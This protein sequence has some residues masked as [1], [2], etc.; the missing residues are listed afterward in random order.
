MRLNLISAPV[1]PV[2][3]VAPHLRKVPLTRARRESLRKQPQ[4]G[5]TGASHAEGDVR[6][7]DFDGLCALFRVPA[8]PCACKSGHGDD[9]CFDA[10]LDRWC[11]AFVTGGER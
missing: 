4:T 5:A 3:P 8:A 9:E 2:A 10:L 1:A 11:I 6:E 7:L